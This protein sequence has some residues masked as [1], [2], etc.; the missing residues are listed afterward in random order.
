MQGK[1][2]LDRGGKKGGGGKVINTYRCTRGVGVVRR[3][4]EW[5]GVGID[6]TL[7]VIRTIF[8]IFH[9]LYLGCPTNFKILKSLKKNK[10]FLEEV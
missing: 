5:E 9:I 4:G 8:T 6:L 1:E 10:C 7:P 2:G 3:V